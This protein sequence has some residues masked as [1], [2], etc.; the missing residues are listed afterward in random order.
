MLILVGSVFAET[1][2]TWREA[3]SHALAT[4]PRI[5]AADA[6]VQAA[7]GGVLLAQAPWEPK[8][9]ANAAAFGDRDEGLAPTGPWAGD[10][11][12]WSS[13]LSLSQA[14]A[15]G[16]TLGVD[17]DLGRTRYAYDLPALD[18]DITGEP[19]YRSS[20]VFRLTERLL[21]GNR[22]ASNLLGV[23]L[24]RGARARAEVERQAAR[25]AVLLE[26][27]D[28]Y[29][30]VWA[31]TAELD[32]VAELRRALGAEPEGARVL[33]ARARAERQEIELRAALETA[34]DRLARAVGERV[35]VASVPSVRPVDPEASIARLRGGNTEL[36]AAHLAVDDAA[37]A[38]KAARQ[39]LLPTLDATAS[40]A[41]HG[42]DT[43]FGASFAELG[44]GALAGWTVGASLAVPLYNRADRG[45]VA[46]AEGRLAAA[47]ARVVQVEGEQID[48]VTAELRSIDAAAQV[49]AL[50]GREAEA[51]GAALVEGADRVE[52]LEIG[53][54]HV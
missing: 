24:A 7:N 13:T 19:L 9:A 34:A 42:Q 23:K 38:L 8:L 53:R 39:S 15:T 4:S 18:M 43:D 11:G 10:V 5:T 3:M 49:E 29:W 54:A 33:A 52:L 48:A 41:L 16:T 45:A 1:A 37:D 26:A 35:T 21:E 46:I 36:L 6:G 17:L 28:A 27:G 32:A 50:A 20:L 40:Y 44:S 2:M 12:G 31:L 25:E 51:L 30:Q 22:M 14:I 47:Q